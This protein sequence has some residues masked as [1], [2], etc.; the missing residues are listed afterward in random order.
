M[1]SKIKRQLKCFCGTKYFFNVTS[2]TLHSLEVTCWKWL[3]YGYICCVP[4]FLD[5]FK[6]IYGLTHTMGRRG[7]FALYGQPCKQI[8]HL[9]I[10]TST[11]CGDMSKSPTQNPQR[12]SALSLCPKGDDNTRSKLKSPKM[13]T[14][15]DPPAVCH[16]KVGS[17]T[18]F[19]LVDFLTCTTEVTPGCCPCFFVLA[20]ATYFLQAWSSWKSL[21]LVKSPSKVRGLFKSWKGMKEKS[22]LL[23]EG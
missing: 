1:I 7:S 12:P 15:A 2:K 9:W 13:V 11:A 17:L 3:V 23:D 22:V 19:S 14:I 16:D 18:L 6:G 4:L 10:N 8:V 21:C 5:S 20:E